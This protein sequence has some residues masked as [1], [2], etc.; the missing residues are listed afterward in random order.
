ME[1]YVGRSL[2]YLGIGDGRYYGLNRETRRNDATEE[3]IVVAMRNSAL[4]AA[5]DALTEKII[6]AALTVHK[7][8]GPGLLEGIYQKGMAAELRRLE[9]RVQQERKY[10][11]HYQG[12]LIGEHRLDL[13]IESKVV[14]ELKAVEGLAP[15][16]RAQLLTY[17][18]MSGLPIGLLIN[19]GTTFIQVKR[20]LNTPTNDPSSLRP[21]VPPS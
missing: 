10:A 2:G 8:L 9:L 3:V 20:V 1:R 6:G 19:F 4:S 7:S 5:E 11:V 18:R 15:V 13:V 12:V 17:L 21:P 16:H 14:L